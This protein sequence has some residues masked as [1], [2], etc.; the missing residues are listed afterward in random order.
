MNNE[1]YSRNPKEGFTPKSHTELKSFKAF[2]KKYMAEQS[3]MQPVKSFSEK[4]DLTP[5]R[6]PDKIRKAKSPNPSESKLIKS[7]VLT[8]VRS[9]SEFSRKYSLIPKESL[10]PS[11]G[12]DIT[13]SNAMKILEKMQP[14]NFDN[15]RIKKAM[16]I[17][18]L[19]IMENDM[20]KDSQYYLQKKYIHHMAPNYN[21]PPARGLSFI[22]RQERILTKYKIGALSEQPT[23]QKKP[24][25]QSF[26]YY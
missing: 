3:S 25:I 22:D 5:V 1:N 24:L 23:P 11:T 21:E 8:S 2:H 4:G 18:N 20:M 17:P 7:A 19:S 26:S 13:F 12:K 6:V 14:R 10:K 15:E 9:E 16:S